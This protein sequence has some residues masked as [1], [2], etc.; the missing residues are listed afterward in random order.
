[1]FII[2][3]DPNNASLVK[4][5]NV[6][7]NCYISVIVNYFETEYYVILSN[8]SKLINSF[9]IVVREDNVI[10]LLIPANLTNYISTVH[11]NSLFKE[12]DGNFIA[13]KADSIAHFVFI[14]STENSGI[15]GAIVTQL[16]SSTFLKRRQIIVTCGGI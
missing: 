4:L 9:K 6:R 10:N 13:G 11:G 12:S 8:N 15:D 14:N 5:K 2:E 1:M 16:A 3:A 7:T